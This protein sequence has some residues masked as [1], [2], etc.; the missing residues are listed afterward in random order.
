MSGVGS[1]CGCDPEKVFQLADGDAEGLNP[2]QEREVREHVVRCS[3]CQELYERE[4]ALNAYLNSLQF[5]KPRP[6]SQGVA[7]ALPTRSL[8]VRLFWGSLGILLL[9]A[10]FISLKTDDTEPVLLF[11]SALGA[12]WGVVASV[13]DVVHAV[14][15]VAGPAS[16]LLLAVGALADL[17]VAFAVLAVSRRRQTREV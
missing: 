10:A 11:M 15:V 12:C 9:A 13:A 7:M 16:L 4:L 1:P 3:G 6:V 5:K 8:G 14:L 17:V 2:E